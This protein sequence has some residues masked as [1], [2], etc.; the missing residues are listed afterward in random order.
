MEKEKGQYVTSM[1]FKKG[2]ERGCGLTKSMDSPV[3]IGNTGEIEDLNRDDEMEGSDDQM[4]DSAGIRTH[5]QDSDLTL[6]DSS[7]D[8]DG[9]DKDS[10]LTLE[11]SSNDREDSSKD[12]SNDREDSSNDCDN[13]TEAPP[14]FSHLWVQCDN[15]YL[16]NYK[17]YFYT[18]MY[19][20]EHCGWHLKMNSS[21]RID[22]SIDP[23]TW[24]PMDEDMVSIDPIEWDSTDDP[25]DPR[26][27]PY[28]PYNKAFSVLPFN[29]P[30]DPNPEDEPFDPEDEPFDPEDEPF[31]P[32]DE[33][34][35]PYNPYTYNPGI[36]PI[37][38]I[39]FNPEDEYFNQEEE[40]FDFDPEDEF[41]KLFNLNPNP[42]DELFNPE[43]DEP[44]KDRLLSYQTQTGLSEAIQTG[45]GELNGIPVAVGVM[46]FEFIGGSMASVVGEKITRLI[47]YATNHALPLII[48]C[49]SGGARMQEGSVSLMQMIKISSTLYDS[50]LNKK[51]FYISILASPTTGG[52]T[53]SFGML[54]DII[55]AEPNAYIAFAGKRIIEQ[56]LNI[57]VPEGAQETE[58][59]FDKGSFD[60]IVPR[61]FLKI[62]LTELFKL[63]GFLP[64][65]GLPLKK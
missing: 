9:Q 12:S 60:L 40:P 51:L 30:F 34:F 50:Q 7:N 5:L 43:D 27:N 41:F 46:D 4:E 42:A 47:E 18:K 20:C 59:L 32:E 62:V 39:T 36:K 11:D 52:V 37:S 10:D 2:L 55:I 19:I 24:N 28:N 44:Y 35:D 14:D 58:N 54:G 56:L 31:D 16:L 57:E 29:P 8:I 25:E 1:L 23:D 63:H 3:P 48:V 65:K 17:K 45:I 21:D 6:E 22:L 49:A 33:P 38:V 53:A 61:N 15:C 26:Y 13:A 64:V